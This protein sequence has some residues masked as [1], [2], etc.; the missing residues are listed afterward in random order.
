[1]FSTQVSLSTSL[2]HQVIKFFSVLFNF[3]AVLLIRFRF[4]DLGAENSIVGELF[5][6][7]KQLC[8]FNGV[9]YHQ[10]TLFQQLG[11]VQTHL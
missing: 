2:K 1:M 3:K 8:W 7:Q 9:C 4:L 10:V 11:S 5:L 6:T